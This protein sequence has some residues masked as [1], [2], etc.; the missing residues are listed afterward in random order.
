MMAGGTMARLRFDSK[1]HKKTEKILTFD[2]NNPHS[3]KKNTEQTKY[4][5]IWRV[6]IKQ[7]ELFSRKR[8]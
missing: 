3:L 8:R 4:H 6:T 1:T 2:Y 7:N 5:R